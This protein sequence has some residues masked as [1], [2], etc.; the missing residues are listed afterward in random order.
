MLF[1]IEYNPILSFDIGIMRNFVKFF[2]HCPSPINNASVDLLS[3]QA[4]Q[5][6][7]LLE[8]NV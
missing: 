5:K 4:L 3:F 1:L 7:P 6:V 2:L 8:A